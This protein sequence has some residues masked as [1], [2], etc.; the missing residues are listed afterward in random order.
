MADGLVAG[1]DGEAADTDELVDGRPAAHESFV[2]DGDM[3]AQQ[4]GIGKDNIRAD[5]AIM[6][7]MATDHEHASVA[8]AG[9]MFWSGI[10]GA[11][12]GSGFAD[13]DVVAD[14]QP[15]ASAVVFEVLRGEPDISGGTDT[16]VFANSCMAMDMTMLIDDGAG[17]KRDVGF[18]D[19][20][21]ADLHIVGKLGAGIDNC[22]RMDFAHITF[23]QIRPP[24]GEQQL[25]RDLSHGGPLPQMLYPPVAMG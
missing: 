11:V 1:D 3:P 12:Y 22:R 18:N 9:G 7:D 10:D 8:D 25:G 4:D 6:T 2:A 16:A 5:M 14:D 21:S 17:A 23:A 24:R 20:V 15:S 19:A 13:D